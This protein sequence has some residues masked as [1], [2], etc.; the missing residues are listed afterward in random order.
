MAKNWQLLWSSY[1]GYIT[2]ADPS[3]PAFRSRPSVKKQHRLYPEPAHLNRP[4]SSHFLDDSRGGFKH[5]SIYIG[6]YLLSFN[7]WVCSGIQSSQ[8]LMWFTLGYGMAQGLLTTCFQSKH[9]PDLM[10]STLFCSLDSSTEAPISL[11]Q[12]QS[13]CVRVR[14]V[15]SQEEEKQLL[16]ERNA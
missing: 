2:W 5:S 11:S 12:R 7:L 14:R 3:S 13:H 6:P 15:S 10:F 8:E 1:D 9:K 4:H 16:N